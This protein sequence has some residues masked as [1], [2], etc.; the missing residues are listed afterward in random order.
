MRK[1]PIFRIIFSI[2]AVG[3]LVFGIYCIVGGV[4]VRHEVLSQ[5]NKHAVD[6]Q[7]DLS[8]AGEYTSAFD[9]TWDACH[10]QTIDLII[11]PEKVREISQKELLKEM[12]FKW[13][14]TDAEGNVIADGAS[15]DEDYLYDTSDSKSIMLIYFHPIQQGKYNFS[16]DVTKGYAALAGTQQRLIATYHPCGLEMMAAI[17]LFVIGLASLA[18]GTTIIV[19]VVGVLPISFIKN[20][21]K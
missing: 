3:L 1:I 4:M 14:I 16:L 2:I 12:E 7:V 6:M 21:L 8:M 18:T 13:R 11:S 9:Q 19:V 17:I 5:Q 20:L 15:S 10:G